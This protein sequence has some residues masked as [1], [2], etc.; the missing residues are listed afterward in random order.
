MSDRILPFTRHYRQAGRSRRSSSRYVCAV[1][2]GPIDLGHT[3]CST[4]SA[5]R[6]V[7]RALAEFKRAQP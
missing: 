6:N 2:R 5:Y 1:C 4:C 7:G 3:L